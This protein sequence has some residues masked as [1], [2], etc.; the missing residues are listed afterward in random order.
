MENTEAEVLHRPA[1]HIK[2]VLVTAEVPVRGWG[3]RPEDTI[4]MDASFYVNTDDW[5][6]EGHVAGHPVLADKEW[7]KEQCQKVAWRV[8]DNLT[9]LRV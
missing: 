6:C 7:W 2:Q 8:R 5:T 4:S 9:T 3:F 1:L